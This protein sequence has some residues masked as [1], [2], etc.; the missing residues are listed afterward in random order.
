MK[1]FHPFHCSF[2]SDEV[3]AY[4]HLFL[5]NDVRQSRIR[6]S[7]FE[8]RERE[9]EREKKKNRSNEHVDIIAVLS[10]TDVCVYGKEKSFFS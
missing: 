9:R 1:R 6:K 8:M 10:T 7:H 4:I 3:L 5:S 2:F